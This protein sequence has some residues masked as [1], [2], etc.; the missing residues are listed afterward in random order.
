MTIENLEIKQSID[1]IN[2][3]IQEIWNKIYP[4]GSI[5][6]S[7]NSTSP[8][9]LFGGTWERWG[10]GRFPLSLDENDQS[11]Q[12][13]KPNVTGGK[14]YLDI[15]SDMLPAHTHSFSATTNSAGSHTHSISI[16]TSNSGAHSH[17]YS[18]TTS[19]SGSHSHM[20]DGNTS[21]K[22]MQ[23]SG[24]NN[25]FSKDGDTAAFYYTRK[26]V[27]NDTEVYTNSAGAH[28]HT[29]SGNTNNTG[30]HTHSVSGNSGS[31]GAHTHTVSG[32]TGSTGKSSGSQVGFMPP[33]ITCYMWRRTA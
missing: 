19:S 13:T 23:L 4:I 32:T 16:T 8:S 28:T 3:E 9:T 10:K 1:K 33:W 20:S 5:Y 24:F 11:D 18:G 14:D 26:S 17:T 21:H 12:Y 29:Y 2:T 15:T 31:N 6:I 22:P 25:G 30:G 27:Q 7:V